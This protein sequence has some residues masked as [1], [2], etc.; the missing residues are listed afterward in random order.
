M[1][2]E[3]KWWLPFPSFFR[4]CAASLRSFGWCSLWAALLWAALR[5]HPCLVWCCFLLFGVSLLGGAAL[6]SAFLR[7][8]L[9]SSLP[10]LL[11]LWVSCL[12]SPTFDGAARS[13]S[14]VGGAYFSA[15][16]CGVLPSSSPPL[17]DAAVEP[18]FLN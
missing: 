2:V 15:S 1:S 16:L 18:C 14:L 7:V 9:L 3:V 11:L 13:L 5:F 4:V 8:L 10:W 17:G 6:S 12:P